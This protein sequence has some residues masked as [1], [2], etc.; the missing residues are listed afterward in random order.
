MDSITGKPEIY[1]IRAAG[2]STRTRI[3][4]EMTPKL[5]RENNDWQA[6]RSYIRTKWQHYR[7]LQNIIYKMEEQ[8]KV[9]PPTLEQRVINELVPLLLAEQYKKALKVS[10]EIFEAWL[11]WRYKK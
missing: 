3:C 10:N 9:Y 4:L 1:V 11:E 5:L 6:A 7:K 8:F 2:R